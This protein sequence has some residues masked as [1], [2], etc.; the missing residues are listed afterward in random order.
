[1]LA[2]LAEAGEVAPDLR[3]VDVGVL[4]QLLRG[5]RLLAHLARLREHL[6]VAREA[7]RDAEREAVGERPGTVVA[8]AAR[9]EVPEAHAAVTLERRGQRLLVEEELADLL[10][11]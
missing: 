10:P 1:A 7:R 3:R 5:D 9:G 2:E 8:R 11:V 4:R 6:E